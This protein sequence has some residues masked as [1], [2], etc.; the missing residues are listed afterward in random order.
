MT[1]GV[2]STIE[3]PAV[4]V[5]VT[6]YN[7]GRFLGRCIESVLRQTFRDLELI[8]VNDGSTD[9]T[10]DIALLY[11]KDPRVRYIKQDNA[12]QTRAKNNGIKASCGKFVAFLDAD[13]FWDPTKLE[14][15]LP[16]FKDPD[17]GVVYS[18][19]MFIDEEGNPLHAHIASRY[20]QPR[21][22]CVTH[23]LLFDNFIPFSSAVVR[24]EVFDKVGMFDETLTMG[25]DWDLW[26]RTSLHYT[27]AYVDEPLLYYRVGHDGQM[28]KNVGKR[29]EASDEI[30]NRFI[31][32][33]SD[34]IDPITI[35]RVYHYT[36]VNRGN[37]FRTKNNLAKSTGY[38]LKA[39]VQW[40]FSIVPFTFLLKNAVLYLLKSSY[41]EYHDYVCFILSDLH[42]YNPNEDRIFEHIMKV[43]GFRYSFLMRTARYLK[44]RECLFGKVLYVITRILLQ[45][46]KIRFGID[47]PYN[48]EIGHGLYIGH[49]G[50]IV[51]NHD[52]R[53]GR[54]CNINHGVTIGT[55]Y[56]G[57]HPGTPVIG[58]NVYL[59]P[60][61]KIIGGIKI[62]NNVAVGA[63]A[64]V[65]TH[66]PDNAIV[67]GVPARI[68][69]YKGSSDYV[70]NTI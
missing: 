70:I 42:R 6:C 69:S 27:F 12:G 37:H 60:G 48:T 16:M 55:T 44:E 43:P 35:R 9:N 25:I 10:E 2:R 61:S 47:I 33:N 40:P 26:L 28:S 45:R 34:K 68:I 64:V 15:Q 13:D 56:G 52:A 1:N 5:I 4:S 38:F 8:I 31:L 50:G 17:V 32:N 54:N 53:I 22:G 46:C 3:V 19:V 23:Y 59:G 41:E 62:G 20:L 65:T 67:A 49:H 51:V 18:R 11:I 58:D 36:F 29:H 39:F 63:N 30:F 14:K 21:H 66:V 7:Y 24:R 57:K